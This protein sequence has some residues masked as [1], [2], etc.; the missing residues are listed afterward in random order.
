MGTAGSVKPEVKPAPGAE[1]PPPGATPSPEAEAAGA[2]VVS[3]GREAV[4]PAGHQNEK[5][6]AL[7]PEEPAAALPSRDKAGNEK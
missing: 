4:N 3:G 5:T 2:G 1:E 6:G 7:P